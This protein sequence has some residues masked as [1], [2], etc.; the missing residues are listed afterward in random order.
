M[1]TTGKK[2]EHLNQLS[3][4]SAAAVPDFRQGFSHSSRMRPRLTNRI[5]RAYILTKE[6]NG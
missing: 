2:M 4:I 3:K 5:S 6:S 1:I